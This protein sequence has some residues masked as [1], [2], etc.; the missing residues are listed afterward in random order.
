MGRELA[1][2]FPIARDTFAEADA[3]LGFPLSRL[4][5]E[6]PEEE[7]TLTINAQ[8]AILTHTIA[9]W[10]IL[11]D[12][13]P[14]LVSVA[15]G[16]SLGEFSA[17][18]AAGSMD[19]C[20]AVRLVHRRGDLMYR[21]GQQRAGSMA[22]ILGL[23]DATIDEVCRRASTEASGVAVPA[24]YNSPGQTVIS[25][26]VESVI[27]A[28]VMAKEAG[29]KRAIPLTVSGAFHSPLMESAADGFR[30]ALDRI[31]IADPRFPVVSNVTGEPV[32][33]AA[34]VR[35][36]LVRQLTA[37]VQWVRSVRRMIAMGATDLL[38]LGPGHVLAGLVRRIDRSAAVRSLGTPSELEA[39]I[40]ER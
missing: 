6:G 27:R 14:L 28:G 24:N 32:D 21:A 17:Y 39:I 13:H 16:H 3:A 18:V 34:D 26:D 5:W 35:D 38:E 11:A 4:S 33:R 8:P 37:P 19:F 29:A 22:A 36:L 25:G 23:D 30:A 1:L 12:L 2:A 20:D 10:R 31:P 9:V 40:A 7:L 15:A